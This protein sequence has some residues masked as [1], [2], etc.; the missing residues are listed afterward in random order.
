MSLPSS[1][2][3]T[4]APS[5]SGA[6][7]AALFDE[8]Q[9][10]QL[11]EAAL[12]SITLSTSKAQGEEFFRVLVKDLAQAMQVHYVIAGELCQ[13]DD[14][15]GIQTL[16][17]WGGSDYMP[18]IS[19]SLAST[20]CRN[21]TDQSMCFLPCDVQ[22][23][24][25]EDLLLVEMGA[26]SYIGMPM[27]GS[28]GKTLGILVALDVRPMA[29]DTR[30]LALSLLSIFAARCA[31]ELQ[32]RRREVELEALVETRTQALAEAQALL[33]EREKLAALGGMLAGMAHEVNTPVGVA[34][35]SSSGLK[36]Y[37]RELIEAVRAEKVSRSHLQELSL[38]IERAGDLVQ[39][40]LER[41]ADLLASFQTLTNAQATAAPVELLLSQELAQLLAAHWAEFDQ[42][43]AHH[44]LD[45]P[46]G[47]R[48]RLPKG[49]L[50]QMVSNLLMNALK[51]GC[52]EGRTLTVT[53]KAN[54]VGEDLHLQV[55]DDGAGV[56]PDVRAHMLEPFY[57]TKRGQGGTGLGLHLV[58][59]MVQKLGG[60]LSL[61]GAPGSG[62]VVDIVLPHCVVG[63]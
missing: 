7:G 53:I 44:C 46:A 23:A 61:G 3:S 43:G 40:N 50:G 28:D 45:V 39:R 41:A 6:S 37:A 13:L 62:L 58:F 8:L 56:A 30:L 36:T 21:V 24:Y 48:V 51:H 54:A 10:K 2:N 27:V 33:H 59:M 5:T 11:A 16:A 31:S 29:E 52:V 47:L 60:Q 34:I 49:S 12:R 9:A 57:T 42:R 38:R 17:V 32:H 14:G 18:N 63:V 20:P 19:Y 15:E 1:T 4:S 55:R 26:Q 35:T 22:Q 25:P